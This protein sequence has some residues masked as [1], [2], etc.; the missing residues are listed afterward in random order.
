MFESVIT[1]QM[2]TYK[3]AGNNLLSFFY[4]ERIHAEMFCI[5][6]QLNLYL[7]SCLL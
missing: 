4:S 1:E 7:T 6:I 2:Y 5:I 3:D